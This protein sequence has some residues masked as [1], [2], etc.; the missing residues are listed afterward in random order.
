MKKKEYREYIN[1][2]LQDL[3]KEVTLKRKEVNLSWA[4][5]KAGK[6]KNLKKSLNL[7]RDI[8]RI[9]TLIRQ[10]EIIEK[11]N[12]SKMPNKKV[13]TAKTKNENK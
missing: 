9:L 3:R 13:K 11:E 12:E 8:A 4:Q 5:I 7:R 10:K 6:E 1:K 2:S